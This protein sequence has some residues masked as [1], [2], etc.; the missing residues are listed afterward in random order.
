MYKNLKNYSVLECYTLNRYNETIKAYTFEGKYFVSFFFIV[1]IFL[2]CTCL[3]V[4]D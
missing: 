2:P 4:F 3:E 1:C